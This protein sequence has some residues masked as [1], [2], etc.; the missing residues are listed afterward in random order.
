MI[1][2]TALHRCICI[3]PITLFV[4]ITMTLNLNAQSSFLDAE[5]M[6]YEIPVPSS[7][8]YMLEQSAESLSIGPYFEDGREQRMV[9]NAFDGFDFDDNAAETVPRIELKLVA[10]SSELPAEGT[11]CFGG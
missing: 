11:R 8:S 10:R 3:L 2:G 6:V 9:T 1:P 4:I 7:G 5:N